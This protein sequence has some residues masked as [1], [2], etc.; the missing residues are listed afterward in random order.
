MAGSRHVEAVLLQDGVLRVYLSD[1]R[2]VP[3]ALDG[4]H[5]SALVTQGEQRTRLALE[6]RGEALEARTE[7]PTAATVDVRVEVALPG[8]PL[9]IDFTLP[10]TAHAALLSHAPARQRAA[11]RRERGEWGPARLCRV[12]RGG[13]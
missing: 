2:R 6:P 5:G 8:E 9:L 3:L 10:V 11:D 4:V 12:G 13:A 1:L 7:P